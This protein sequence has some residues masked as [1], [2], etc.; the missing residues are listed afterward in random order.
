[1]RK[2]ENDEETQTPWKL[3]SFV[4]MEMTDHCQQNFKQDVKGK[5][6][7][8]MFESRFRQNVICK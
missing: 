7:T 1:M 6:D 5:T 4:E 2:R 8:G 3:S